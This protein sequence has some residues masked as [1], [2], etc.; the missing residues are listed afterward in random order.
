MQTWK[1]E[2]Q[3]TNSVSS[4]AV[5]FSLRN[6]PFSSKIC[7]L[8]DVEGNSSQADQSENYFFYIIGKL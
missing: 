5:A 3:W 2:E 4:G 8:E 6:V 7:I 1:K